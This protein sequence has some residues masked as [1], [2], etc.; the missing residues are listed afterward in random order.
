MTGT[1]YRNILL[2]ILA[3]AIAPIGS[4]FVISRFLGAK[5]RMSLATFPVRITSI[6]Y[7]QLLLNN[8]TYNFWPVAMSRWY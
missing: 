4:W 3:L 8:P 2:G 5:V 6:V 7:K 1:W